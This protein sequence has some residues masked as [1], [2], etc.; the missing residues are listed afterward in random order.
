MKK[1][2]SVISIENAYGE[3]SQIRRLAK[4][5]KQNRIATVVGI[6]LLMIMCL[7]YLDFMKITSKEIREMSY[8]NQ[9]RAGSKTLT[10]SV[11]NYV[12]TSEERYCDDYYKELNEDRN[13][14][15]AWEGLEHD[16][17]QEDEWEGLRKIAEL[18]DGLVPLETEAMVEVKNGNTPLARKYVFDS[19]YIHT[20]T[21]ISEMADEVIK[22]INARMEK[23]K[24]H[25]AIASLVSTGLFAIGFFLLI[26]RNRKTAMFTRDELL[27]P[28]VKISN[29]MDR[30]VEGKLGACTD[31][32]PDDSEMGKMISDIIR[33]KGNLTLIID[34]IAVILEQMGKCDYGVKIRQDYVGDYIQIKDSLLKI[35]AD[36]KENIEIIQQV[37]REVDDS[38]SQLAQAADELANACTS[39][40]LQIS[41][42]SI[43]VSE[44]SD[45][46]DNDEQEAEEAG[47]IANLS[48]ST[49]V[50]ATQL[51]EELKNV[52]QEMIECIRVIDESVVDEDGKIIIDRELVVRLDSTVSQI[53]EIVLETSDS[54]GDVIV[55]AEEMS[56]RV[57][58]IINN[59]KTEMEAIHHINEDMSVVAGIVDLNSATAEETAAVSEQQ[60]AL[61]STMV[62]MIDKFKF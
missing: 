40:A 2:D 1:A 41:D 3:N 47:K 51:M 57:T 38:S 11:Q 62:S 27:A 15:K 6:V 7:L 49:L 36:T 28:V 59:F 32:I 4:I 45:S 21:Q 14:D 31:L 61:V 18:S 35:A 10:A 54:I 44:L 60:S 55:G 53:N 58:R 29:L 37:V 56:E 39:Q 42:V 20:T 24:R 48:S 43:L 9:Y 46:I 26:D 5:V 22:K 34:E 33:M 30:L 17:L 52:T 50:M 16:G 25:L 12:I 19:Y 23:Q 13:R 8:L